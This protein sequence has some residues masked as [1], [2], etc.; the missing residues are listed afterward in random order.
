MAITTYSIWTDLLC[1]ESNF[2]NN[3][4]FKPFLDRKS[5]HNSNEKHYNYLYNVLPTQ[6][7]KISKNAFTKHFTQWRESSL[8]HF[9]LTA[10]MLFASTFAK[11][12]LNREISNEVIIVSF[13]KKKFHLPYLMD[14]LFEK[15]KPIKFRQL[16]FLKKFEKAIEKLAAGYDLYG[17]SAC[18]IMS[19]FK[20]YVLK[21]MLPLASNTQGVEARIKDVS[22][23]KSTGKSEKIVTNIGT[24]RSVI[25]TDV[26]KKIK[27]DTE[28]INRKKQNTKNKDYLLGKTYNRN[29]LM[30]SSSFYSDI[31]SSS[32]DDIDFLKVL[33]SKDK[34]YNNIRIER[35]VAE[36][37]CLSEKNRRNVN[38]NVSN[39][40]TLTPMI[41][42]NVAFGRPCNKL[43]PMYK[44]EL[45]SCGV[46]NMESMDKLTCTALVKAIKDDEHPN[47]TDLDKNDIM[48]KKCEY[49]KYFKPRFL[50]AKEWLTDYIDNTLETYFGVGENNSDSEEKRLNR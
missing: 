6:L 44:A 18:E 37:N 3:E 11:K 43:I 21:F 24:M 16:T 39:D 20:E 34:H 38:A 35:A 10:D 48:N 42:G 2:V 26:I 33:I 1:L 4:S 31:D 5:I 27:K 25:L 28:Y 14:F 32:S 41:V 13:S 23:R 19:P 9:V 12:F 8:L 50:S 47:W 29:I 17:E 7:F 46:Y 36:F 15:C 30:N 49:L 45:L 22:L 40:V